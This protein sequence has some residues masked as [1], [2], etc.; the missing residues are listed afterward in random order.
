MPRKVR[1]RAGIALDYPERVR[2][3]PCRATLNAAGAWQFFAL[4]MMAAL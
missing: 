2:P 3:E 1:V 4:T